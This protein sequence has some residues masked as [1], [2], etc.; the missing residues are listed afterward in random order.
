MGISER[1]YRRMENPTNEPG[2]PKGYSQESLDMLKTDE[3]QLNAVFAC[4]G[5]AAQHA[6]MFEQGL[7][8][9]LIVYNIVTSE[10]VPLEDLDSLKDEL[11]QKTMGALLGELKKHIA[12]PE[13]DVPELFGNALKARNFLM[14]H[15][16]LELGDQLSTSEGRMGLL[17]LLIT[18][19]KT[20]DNSRIM[21]NAMRIATCKTLGLDDEYPH[22][23]ISKN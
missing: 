9:F 16:F 2:E 1:Y 4:F 23:P 18:I 10:G 13:Q 11:G 5:S 14:H 19:E 3:G 12:F 15:F 21:I 8:K 7:S 22:N 17:Q 20:L 6:Q